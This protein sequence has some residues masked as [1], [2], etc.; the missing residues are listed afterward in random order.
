[1]NRKKPFLAASLTLALSLSAALLPLSASATTSSLDD[2]VASALE[3]QLSAAQLTP[4]GGTTLENVT[5]DV[6]AELVAAAGTDDPSALAAYIVGELTAEA[7]QASTDA[8]VQA[9]AS[10]GTPTLSARAAA[11]AK[12]VNYTA[13]QLVPITA[14]G[15][16]WINQDMTVK[17]T[18]NTIN[19][20][21]LNGNSYGTGLS[22]FAYSHINTTL[23]YYKS[24]TCVRTY[25]KGTYSAIVKGSAVSF[26]D[27]VIA[28]DAPRNGGMTSINHSDC[29]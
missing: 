15:V 14:L 22:I 9:P 3:E 11:A 5:V 19:S 24:K 6:S 1:M 20:I 13:D 7:A 16:G 8:Q 26:A 25:M 18:G 23:K 12:S 27:T 4:N 10:V 2:A 28:A 21:T 17:F 29:Q